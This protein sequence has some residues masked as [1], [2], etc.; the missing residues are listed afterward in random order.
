MVVCA[1]GGAVTYATYTLYGLT[2]IYST[3][4]YF[5]LLVRAARSLG[6]APPPAPE[7][8][9]T[10][11]H[12]TALCSKCSQVLDHSLTKQT[13]SDPLFTPIIH[14]NPVVVLT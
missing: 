14:T 3:S 7:I 5:L 4:L 10:S 1:C 2:Y 9:D 11:R 13:A 6:V 12:V 8:L